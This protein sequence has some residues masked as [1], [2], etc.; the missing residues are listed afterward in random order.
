MRIIN[1]VDDIRPVNFG[2]WSASIIT[3]PSLQAEYGVESEIWY[4]AASA[5]S[6]LPYL[7]GAYANPL[8]S[9]DKAEI[10]KQIADRGLSPTDTIICTHGCWRYA[11]I[12]GR[13]FQRLG[14]VWVYTPQ[15]MLEPW[16][17]A[18]KALKKKVYFEL[19]EKPLAKKA[20]LVRA[21]GSPEQAN[22]N[23][24]FKHP[25]LM[26]N[27][28]L[29]KASAPDK[30]GLEVK[31][32]LFMARLHYKKGIIPLVKAWSASPLNQNEHWQLLIA[33]PDDGELKQL[34]E[35]LENAGQQS[36]IHYL[37]PIY[38]EEKEAVLAKSQFYILPTLSEGFPTSVVE[39]MQSGLIP[40][41]TDGANFPEAFNANIGIK[42]TQKVEDIVSGL[43]QAMNLTPEHRKSI[44]ESA[45]A[46]IENGYMVATQAKLQYDT[47][48]KLLAPKASK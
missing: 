6:E 24:H 21:V 34:N 42:I 27:G 10:Q 43:T 17:M 23:T 46:F 1:I 22:L 5:P 3:A 15:G 37:G 31:S 39:A 12:W 29:P 30:N 18:Q 38:K 40:I 11:T 14:Y 28:V 45:K 26:P 20:T 9:T 25:K 48:S 13:E 19:V 2:I 32:V 7:Y 44:S 41:I 47:F 16:S 33:G 36:N 4:P 35:L 8:Q